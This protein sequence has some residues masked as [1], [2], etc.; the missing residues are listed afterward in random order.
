M[1]RTKL[2]SAR[3][4]VLLTISAASVACT[5]SDGLEERQEKPSPGPVPAAVDFTAPGRGKP[6]SPGI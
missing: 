6:R 4:L 1:P 3:G 2:T 5:G